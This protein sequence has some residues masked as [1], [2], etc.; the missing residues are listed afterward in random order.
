[1]AKDLY[2]EVAAGQPI[3]REGDVG[4][5]MFIVESGNVD[6]VRKGVTVATLEAGDFFGEMAILED[7]PRF[8]TAQ[9]K[10]ACRLLKI[11]RASFADLLRQNVE[12]AVR[13]MR[14]LVAR[15][16]R[17]E[18]R[19]IDAEAELASLKGGARPETVPLPAGGDKPAGR[20]RSSRVDVPKVPDAV[21]EKPAGR[22]RSSKVDVPKVP[23][24]VAE[25]RAPARPAPVPKVVACVL[26]HGV[27]GQRFELDPARSEF[28]IGRPDPVTGMTPEINLG[29]LDNARSLSR[30]HAKLLCEGGLYFLREEVGTT[31]GTFVNGQRLATG[32]TAALKPGDKLRFGTVEVELTAA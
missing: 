5:E 20:G 17:A 32:T 28:L 3:F 7:Q 15:Q 23:D 6:I 18:Q 31:N 16:R 29:P 2:T 27:T 19:A 30:R 1:M 11:E 25:P 13:I 12:I 4:T 14:K 21:P 8:A 22:G 10:T 24:A 26:V 9:A